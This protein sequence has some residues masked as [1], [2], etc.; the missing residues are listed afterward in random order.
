MNFYIYQGDEFCEDCGRDICDA[1]RFARK[2]PIN[3]SDESTYD[4]D[5]YPKGPYPTEF[6]KADTPQYCDSCH[7]FL[8]NP[9][10]EEGY[11][12]VKDCLLEDP[13]DSVLEWADFYNVKSNKL[14]E[15]G[16]DIE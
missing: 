10:T 15:D 13:S 6:N 4:S 2:T 9:L 8:E 3:P 11:Q 5:D 1:L 12:F 14:T 16:E 7:G